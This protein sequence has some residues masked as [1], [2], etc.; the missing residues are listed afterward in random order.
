[1]KIIFSILLFLFYSVNCY[2]Q[3]AP[4]KGR[5]ELVTLG[6]G[7]G[8][9]SF[10]GDMGT[11]GESTLLA[12]VRSMFY[13]NFERRFGKVLGAQLNASFGKLSY[14]ER[15]NDVQKNRNFESNTM[16]LGANLVLH[17]DNDVIFKRETPF[18]PYI[19]AGFHYLTF[20]SYTDL[21]DKDG[22]EYQYWSD[23]TI[24]DISEEN[25]DALESTILYRDYEYETQLKDSSVN[26]NR[27]SFAI[28]LTLG[29]KWKIT[30]RFN[31]RVFGTYNI[32]LSDWV[33]NISENGDNDKNINVGFGLHYV[34]KIKDK[35][36]RHLYDDVDFEALS[37]S[38]SD[39]DGIGDAADKCQGTPNGIEVNGFGCP[40]DKDK[41]GVADYL[42]KE[43]DTKKGAIVD[44]QGRTLTDEM[45][46][47]RQEEK[48]ALVTERNISFSEEATGATLDKIFE[49]IQTSDYE[50]GKIPSH[51]V[52]ADTNNDGL[53]S[54]VEVSNAMD[55][56][57]D[58]NSSLS[59]AGIH[60]LIDYFFEQ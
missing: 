34:L 49:E 52:E 22:T 13:A 11:K 12:N 5:I 44:E 42:D 55:A 27:N 39:K 32:I 50:G 17:F 19:S 48:I 2:S 16:Q 37:N 9:S 14:N 33:D 23:G 41:D 1:M 15:S 35:E 40:L 3:Y 53:I 6:A 21:K 24:N 47:K 25:K 30:P 18:A 58:G 8:F 59:V 38:D 28:P 29:L 51:L 10:I 57:F 60:E 56:F 20:D 4:E 46:A 45:I 36:R 7:A 31:G 43:E 54:P 26:Y